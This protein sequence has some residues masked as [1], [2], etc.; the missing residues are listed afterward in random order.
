MQK[1]RK[2]WPVAGVVVFAA[3]QGCA[4]MEGQA[5][6]PLPSQKPMAVAELFFGRDI[7]DRTQVSDEDWASFVDAVVAKQFPIGFTILNGEG[8]WRD[9][10]LGK[11]M[12]EPSKVLI[13]AAAPSA[14]LNARLQTVADAY[15]K[16]FHQ[17]SVGILT[18]QSCGAF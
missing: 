9:P 8:A 12:N 14:E 11:T 18:T 1:P 6:C 17:D 5:D 10:S 2:V 3:L 7:K 4:G 16:Q 15:R 13:V